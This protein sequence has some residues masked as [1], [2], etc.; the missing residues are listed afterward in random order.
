MV[1]LMSKSQASIPAVGLRA[2]PVEDPSWLIEVEGYDEDRERVVEAWFTVANG[3]AGTRGSLE[4]TTAASTA[5]LY[6][7][8]FYGNPED[9]PEDVQLVC[10]PEWT[11]LRLRVGARR[12]HLEWG[13]I[14]ELRRI[15]DLRQGVLFRFWRQRLPS[16]LE[17]DFRSARFASLAD[18]SILALEA[19]AQVLP[20]GRTDLE[21]PI[22]LVVTAVLDSAGMK[23]RNGVLEVC[24]EG[25]HERQARFAL[26]TV[27][28]ASHIERFAGVSRSFA[29]DAEGREA[30][31]ALEQAR[32]RGLGPLL[33]RHAGA[34]AERW[35]DTDVEIAGD[36]GLQRAMRFSLF[37]LICSGDPESDVASIGARGLTG[38]AYNGHVFWDTDVF[39]VPLFTFTHPPTA[40]ALLAYRYRTLPAARQKAAAHGFRG[41]LYA[42]ESAETGEEVTPDHVWLPDGTL[43]PV[44]TGRQEHH[45]SADVAWAVWRYW[46]VTGDDAF[47]LQMGA[48][49]VLETARFWASRATEGTDGRYHIDGVIGP[50]EYHETIR[51]NAY[52]NV[53][54]RWN[55]E[56]GLELLERL[57]ALDAGAWEALAA[58]TGLTSN[59]GPRWQVVAKGLADGFDPATGLHEQFAGFFDLE[60]IRAVD[61]A[62]RPF[63]G[64]GAVGAARLRRSQI[65]KQADVL[66]LAHVLP[67]VMPLEIVRE[68]Y[69]YYEPRTSH[70][71]SLSPAIHAAVAARIGAL[72]DATNYFR[73]AAL[74]D[75][76]DEMGNAADGLHLATMGGLWQ[77]AVM[78]FG[79]VRL[80]G[81][82]GLHI[83]PRV[84]PEWQRLRFP[85]RF[86]GVRLQVDATPD[87]LLLEVDGEVPLGVG[88]HPPGR[89]GR[90]RYRARWENGGWS[91]LQPAGA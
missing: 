15:L 39:I 58:R 29:G 40:R 50:D 42:W 33:D 6:V 31:E 28:T 18:R 35:R 73:M 4:E 22:P 51:D 63:T 68:N 62:E 57:P 36:A 85:L 67:E 75:L 21:A 23:R 72:G 49:I 38:P 10:G 30:A 61:I 14:L 60:N 9:Q 32:E 56:R 84:P 19:H 26:A 76:G 86:R 27:A 65:V 20:E 46:Q 41:A 77:A 87:T 8:G 16:G 88:S 66:M 79:G 55:L 12:L 53:L 24:L 34:L 52:T 47:M 82:E 90:G 7:A 78:G 44:L 17:V 54:A 3:R 81:G 89:T 2:F 64:E 69:S 48:E 80:D 1:G 13:E 83:D 91:P 5:S 59:E 37:H 25:R 71:S 43:L 11:R 74:V 45:I 70:G